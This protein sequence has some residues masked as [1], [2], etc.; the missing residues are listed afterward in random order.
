MSLEETLLV[1]WANF[2]LQKPLNISAPKG[3]EGLHQNP[4][5]S[6]YTWIS[7]KITAKTWDS[8]VKKAKDIIESLRQTGVTVQP[9]N[10]YN[11]TSM[12]GLQNVHFIIEDCIKQEAKV[13]KI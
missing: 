11:F 9:E 4:D 5:G 6:H 7:V 13:Y 1:I 10:E 12:D 8:E 3:S 2:R